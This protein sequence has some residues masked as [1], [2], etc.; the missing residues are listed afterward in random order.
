MQAKKTSKSFKTSKSYKNLSPGTK[1]ST[2]GSKNH[3]KDWA[4]RR[5]LPLALA[6][7]VFKELGEEATIA[8]AK[9]E[10]KRRHDQTEASR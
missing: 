10:I 8:Q 3:I 7:T 9:V 4:D 6:S 5:Q 1:L 2:V